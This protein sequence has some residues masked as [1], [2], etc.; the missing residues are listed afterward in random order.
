MLGVTRSVFIAKITNVSQ[1]PEFA[2]IDREPSVEHLN[3]ESSVGQGEYAV[4][5][6]PGKAQRGQGAGK[7]VIAP[8]ALSPNE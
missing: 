2:G 7:Q 6:L 5:R 1:R 4:Y 8:V 3:L